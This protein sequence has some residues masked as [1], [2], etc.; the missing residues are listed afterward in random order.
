MTWGRAV[1]A[2]QAAKTNTNNNTSRRFFI[3]MP[4]SSMKYNAKSLGKRPRIV[5][6]NLQ[7]KSAAC[8]T[9]I[10]SNHPYP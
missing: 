4:F 1:G 6:L 8:E 7:S 9:V 2:V 5:S 10:E 3:N